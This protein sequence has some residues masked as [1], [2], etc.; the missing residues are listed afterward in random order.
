MGVVRYRQKIE[1]IVKLKRYLKYVDRKQYM[2]RSDKL[3]NK[4]D[5]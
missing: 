1:N 5:K 4:K 2:E 3:H